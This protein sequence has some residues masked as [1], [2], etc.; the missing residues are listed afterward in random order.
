MKNLSFIY[1]FLLLLFPAGIFA[2]AT[3]SISGTVKDKNTQELLVG[4]TVLLEG[5]GFGAVADIDG[6]FIIKN[7]PPKSYN[8]KV[9]MI[10]YEPFTLF[11]IVITS[12]NIQNLNI[13]LQPTVIET[14]EVVITRRNF[15][16]KSET[17]LS[18]QNLS[19]E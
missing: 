17:P 4:A 16:K 9:Q 2:Q 14:E 11:N 15:G 13:E 1:T 18:V 19:S 10:G 8:L 12:G 5:T 6:R 7:I 3:G